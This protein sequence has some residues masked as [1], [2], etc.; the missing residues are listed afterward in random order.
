M[1]SRR[2]GRPQC[3]QT[4]TVGAANA[5]TIITLR[6][7]G[8]IDGSASGT[9]SDNGSG[10]GPSGA[11]GDGVS[12]TGTIE[13]LR[14]VGAINGGSAGSTFGQPAAG[15]G[16]SN[17]GR[18]GRPAG[19]AAFDDADVVQKRER[20]GVRKAGAAA[21]SGARGAS[22]KSDFHSL[23][24]D[25]TMGSEDATDLRSCSNLAG[26][27]LEEVFSR[28]SLDL[29]VVNFTTPPGSGSSPVPEPSTWAMLVIGFAAL[30]AAASRARR[31]E[32]SR[33]GC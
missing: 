6:Y 26:L 11:G 32:L 15:A 21:A 8:M 24:L 9:G 14:N 4:A 7:R 30:A 19:L 27:S 1:R 16:V 23:S 10:I 5:G 3:V 33:V 25:G 12:N 31:R 2:S 29:D 20:P 13:T 17:A 22:V 28:N 18:I